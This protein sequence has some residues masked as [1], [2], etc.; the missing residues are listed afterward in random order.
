VTRRM[1][2]LP[3]KLSKAW[4][5]PQC[6]AVPARLPQVSALTTKLTVLAPGDQVQEVPSIQSTSSFAPWRLRARHSSSTGYL[7]FARKLEANLDV[8]PATVSLAYDC[9]P[10]GMEQLHVFGQR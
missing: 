3:P 4:K 7:L 5:I 10:K 9:E 2:P 1:K 6:Q 8:D